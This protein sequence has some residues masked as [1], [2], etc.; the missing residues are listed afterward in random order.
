MEAEAWSILL[1]N[2]Q[3]ALEQ[4]EKK[5]KADE[6]AQKVESL[7]T[8]LAMDLNDLLTR[9][10]F[11][12]V[13]QRTSGEQM[14]DDRRKAAVECAAFVKSCAQSL[15]LMLSR[16][17]ETPTFEEEIDREIRELEAS[18]RRRARE[19]DEILDGTK[20]SLT[21]RM[22]RL[23]RNMAAGFSGGF[24]STGRCKSRE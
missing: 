3:R 12:K 5:G 9:F 1:D 2:T 6:Q 23:A 14:T 19:F 20:P 21:R 22:V 15:S 4:A 7:V 24:T 18:V 16:L 13:R 17:G 8:S 10:Y 11:I